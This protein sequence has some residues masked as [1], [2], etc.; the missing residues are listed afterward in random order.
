MKIL[1]LISQRFNNMYQGALLLLQVCLFL[2]LS[3]LSIT[4]IYLDTAT[5]SDLFWLWCEISYITECFISS[6]LCSFVGAFLLDYASTE[7]K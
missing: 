5:H 7:N 4:Y 6:V 2:I 3:V 1:K